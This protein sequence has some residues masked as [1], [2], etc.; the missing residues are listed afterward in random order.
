MW[1]TEEVL[2]VR[3]V[4][5]FTMSYN[6]KILVCVCVCACVYVWSDFIVCVFSDASSAKNSL[7]YLTE[8]LRFIYPHM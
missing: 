7:T 8:L 6:T 3:Y 1:N 2:T 5:R 4:E